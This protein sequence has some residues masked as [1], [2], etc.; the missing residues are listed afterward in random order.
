MKNNK[1][2]ELK[3]FLEELEKENL[4]SD[5]GDDDWDKVS[6]LRTDLNNSLG[7]VLSQMN[8]NRGNRPDVQTIMRNFQK[9]MQIVTSIETIVNKFA[10]NHG[11]KR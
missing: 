8:V 4:F 6:Q 7:A 9:V 11:H 5:E 3:Y 2:N 10:V 1:L